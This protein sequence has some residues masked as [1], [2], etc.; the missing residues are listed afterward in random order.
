VGDI[1]SGSALRRRTLAAEEASA[2]QTSQPR[3]AF[4]SLERQKM[5]S[6]AESKKACSVVR[7]S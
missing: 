6:L 2:H 7:E 4:T 5:G 3:I 1:N